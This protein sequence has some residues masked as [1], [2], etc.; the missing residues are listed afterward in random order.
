MCHTFLHSSLAAV[1]I[2]L[3]SGCV[4]TAPKQELV[5]QSALAV[6]WMQNAGE[7]EALCYQAFNTA[8]VALDAALQEERT[9]PLAIMVDLDETMVDNSP[10]AAWQ[11][12]Q[13]ET[14][15]TQTW[16]AWV[17][18]VQALALPG[19]VE[20]A[21][22]A[23]EQ[24][25]T[26]FYVS[27]RSDRTWE[28]TRDNLIALGF[29]NVS[30]EILKLNTVTSNKAPRLQTILDAGY[31]VI[32]MMGDNLNDFPELATY[33][34]PNTERN[35]KVAAYKSLFGQRFILLPNPSYGDWEPGLA[36]GYYGLDD[37]AKLKVRSESLDAWA[38]EPAK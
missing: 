2:A 20:F 18:D 37:A 13:G 19:A 21:Q 26:M 22:Y 33:H 6:V 24:G 32:L 38:G 1:T 17:N 8:R 25:V 3:S 14:Y 15:A 31:E 16:D 5:N 10:Y 4:S 11:I 30:R 34:Q 9:Q 7:Y 35:Q 28:A 12:A 23:T 36:E 27:N 29:P